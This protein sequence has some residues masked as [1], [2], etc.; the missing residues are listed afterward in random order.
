MPTLRGRH[1][2]RV[3]GGKKVDLIDEGR[4]WTDDEYAVENP[5]SMQSSSLVSGARIG[6]HEF[7]SPRALDFEFSQAATVRTV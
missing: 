7:Y 6:T 1:A 5:V 4:S 3:D 2:V